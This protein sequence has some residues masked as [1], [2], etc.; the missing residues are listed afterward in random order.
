MTICILVIIITIL[1]GILIGVITK[2]KTVKYLSWG[3][4]GCGIALFL[5]LYSSNT[6]QQAR[7]GEDV[8]TNLQDEEEKS[9]TRDWSNEE[10]T[11]AG[12]EEIQNKNFERGIA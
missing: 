1:I 12:L 3:I 8:L 11:E 4:L 9:D 6:P 7:T 2:N 10:L 5:L